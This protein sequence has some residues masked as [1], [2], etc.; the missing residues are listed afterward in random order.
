MRSRVRE[1]GVG[2]LTVFALVLGVYL[3]TLS[4]HHDSIDGMVM[5][6]QAK[7]VAFAHTLQIDPPVVWD[8]LRFGTSPWD[9]GLTFAYVPVLWML[10]ALGLGTSTLHEVPTSREGLL[11]DASHVRAGVLNA[12]VSAATVALL[13]LLALRVGFAWPRALGS[14]LCLAFASPLFGYQ[15]QD[16]AQP[17]A[18]LLL[19]SAVW[20]V[21]EATEEPSPAQRAGRCVV[22]GVL[23]GWLTMTRS[24]STLVAVVPLVLA[25]ATSRSLGIR[26]LGCLL[27]ACI[28][29]VLLHC[30]INRMEG[31]SAFGHHASVFANFGGVRGIMIAAPGVLVSPGRGLFVFYPLAL[32]AVPGWV[33]MMR[34]ERRTLGWMIGA[35]F[36]ASVALFSIWPVWQ[37]GASWGPRFFAPLFPP[38]AL[39]ALWPDPHEPRWWRCLRLAAV[40]IGFLMAAT[41][42]ILPAIGLDSTC[43][44]RARDCFLPSANPLIGH[45]LWLLRPGQYDLFVGERLSAGS[46]SVAVLLGIAAS[47][48]LVLAS[49][50]RIALV[51]RLDRM[52]PL[53]PTVLQKS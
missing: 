32:F 29:F 26:D 16:W 18:A 14:A 27:G 8:G 19:L 30:E 45:G 1:R 40:A 23:L 25:C 43:V 53:G 36:A 20:H 10:D 28:P 17:L 52:A 11:Y 22:A 51:W 13:Y 33:R 41:G 2:P 39:A 35:L 50:A 38:L 44:F 4:G 9:E 47:A 49:G 34:G 48:S 5:Y 7:R 46:P 15:R 21:H 6:Q 12:V 31:G 42:A 3:P 24:E 37:G